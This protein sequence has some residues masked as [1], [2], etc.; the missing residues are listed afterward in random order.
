MRASVGRAE[1]VPRLVLVALDGTGTD[2]GTGTGTED[3]GWG[4][5]FAAR[6]VL[7]VVCTWSAGDSCR[8]GV[9]RRLG[10]GWDTTPLGALGLAVCGRG[11]RGRGQQFQGPGFRVFGQNLIKISTNAR[12][13]QHLFAVILSSRWR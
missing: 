11:V 2:M 8:V 7:A 1:R 12:S 6:V 9:P 4:G 10:G 5:A 13:K 3:D